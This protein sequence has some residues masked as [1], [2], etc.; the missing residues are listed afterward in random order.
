MR[1]YLVS[2]LLLSVLSNFV[3]GG[4]VHTFDLYGNYTQYLHSTTNAFV[5]NE[6]AFPD[7][8]YWAPIQTNLEAS[9]VYKYDF[10]RHF[11]LN[12]IIFEA[13]FL[14]NAAFSRAICLFSIQT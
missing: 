9:V 5:N 6:A 14:P 4:F 12:S 2:A 3:H 1:L 8:Y 13:H 11:S 7:V 10:T